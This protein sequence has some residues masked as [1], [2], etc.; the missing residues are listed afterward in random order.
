[1]DNLTEKLL[2]TIQEKGVEW[3]AAAL[4]SG[5]IGYYS[6]SE[7]LGIVNNFVESKQL[8]SSER[9]MCC[10]KHDPYSEMEFDF[11]CFNLMDTDRQQK[12][13]ERVKAFAKMVSQLKGTEKTV[14]SW[15]FSAL[16]PTM[17][18]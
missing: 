15:A 13:V 1:M 3:A 12:V 6:P 7:A 4:V 9:T 10:F 14:A 16:A 11:H 2:A 8:F 17:S 5:S 18:L